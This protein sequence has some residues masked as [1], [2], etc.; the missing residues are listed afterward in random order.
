MLTTPFF[1][2]A[3]FQI[4]MVSFLFIT[5]ASFAEPFLTLQMVHM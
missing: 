4:V 5:Y 1:R 2:F 3:F